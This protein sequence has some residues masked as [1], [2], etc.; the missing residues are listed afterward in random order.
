MRVLQKLTKG[1]HPLVCY[2]CGTPIEDPDII[3][4]YGELSKTWCLVLPSCKIYCPP[5]VTQRKRKQA[6]KS[7][8]VIRKR[9]RGQCK[10]AS[11]NVVSKFRK[12]NSGEPHHRFSEAAL[13]LGLPDMIARWD[14]MRAN[15]KREK[16]DK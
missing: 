6:L 14:E 2:N 16:Q 15:K 12:L 1:A 8:K 10:D 7:T 3:A 11:K 9:K 5:H 4:E 13:R